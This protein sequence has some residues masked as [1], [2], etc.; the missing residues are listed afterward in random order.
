MG[1]LQILEQGRAEFAYRKA[2]EGINKHGKEYKQYA[3]KLPMLIK[4]NGLGPT[5][6]FI[7]S[8]GGTYETLYNHIAEWLKKDI[9]FGIFND[10]NKSKDLL[11]AIISLNSPEY[12]AVTNETIA[13]LTWLKRLADGLID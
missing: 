1:N 7:K 8:K 12:R 3:K 11:E 5:L 2:Q 13:F 6:A 10:Q 9:K 4:T